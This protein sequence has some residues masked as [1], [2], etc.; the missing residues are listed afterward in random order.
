ML[1]ALLAVD[2]LFILI[3]LG[4]FTLYRAGFTGEV[5]YMLRVSTDWALPEEFNYLKW[6][7]IVVALTRVALRDRWWT[8]FAWALVFL[9]ILADDSLQFHETFGRIIAETIN[10]QASYMV[11]PSDLGEVAVFGLMGLSVVVLTAFSFTSAG[12]Q[13]RRLSTNYALIIFGLGFFGVGVDFIHQAIV[14]I[15]D[16]MPALSILK[17]AFAMLE[18]GGEMLVASAATALTL[19]PPA[20][21]PAAQSKSSG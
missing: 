11:E 16:D 18:D 2:L 10:L 12:A 1:I 17:H 20:W 9:L 13:S 7:V 8:P 5:P 19:A 6:I 21:V 15:T 3:H 4:W 14:Y